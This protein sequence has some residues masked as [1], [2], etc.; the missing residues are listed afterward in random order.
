ML[1]QQGQGPDFI[2]SIIIKLHKE[3]MSGAVHITG[4]KIEAEEAIQASLLNPKG[5]SQAFAAHLRSTL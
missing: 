1:A 2:T 5:F 4:E 3:N